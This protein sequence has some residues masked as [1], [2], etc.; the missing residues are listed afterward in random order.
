MSGPPRARLAYALLAPLC[1]LGLWYHVVFVVGGAYLLL[2]AAASARHAALAHTAGLT[3]GVWAS[4]RL[5]PV[6]ASEGPAAGGLVAGGPFEHLTPA[7]A[8]AALGVA[9]A[10]AG[11]AACVAAPAL[12]TSGATSVSGALGLS[13]AFGAASG[14]FAGALARAL[15]AILPSPAA[16]LVALRVEVLAP[17]LAAAAFGPA[18]AHRGGLVRTGIGAALCACVVAHLGASSVFGPASARWAARFAALSSYALCFSL[19]LVEPLAP[20]AD[21]ART[22]D[23]LVLAQ[24]GPFGRLLLTSGRGAFQLYVDASLRLSTID[25]ARAR[26]ALAHPALA[27]ASR[28][29]RVL[30]VGGG[31]GAVAAEALRYGDVAEVTIVEPDAELVELGR[32][33]PVLVR[34]NGGALGSPKVRVVYEDPLPFL[35]R[36]GEPFD[37]AL[38]DMGEP[39]APVRSKLYTTYFFNLVRERLTEGGT[40]AVRTA[41]P[42][43]ARRAHWCVVRTLEAAGLEVLAYR[44]GL[45][46]SGEQGYALFGRGRLVRPDPSRLPPGLAFLDA[47]ELDALFDWPPDVGPLPVEVNRLY[48]QVLH[49]YRDEAAL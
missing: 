32:S 45:P 29:A 44:A 24:R 30:V 3:A 20:W 46:A 10:L 8:L 40:G 4:R 19:A 33:Q 42:L 9:Q 23:P 21:L 1:G 7:A 11:A 49:A 43:A 34:E 18:L 25:A 35:A 39:D 16:L 31:D 41:P 6:I 37:V 26:E 14:A 12:F 13:L 47:G 28:R 15:P 27:A 22:P 5:V 2:D 38:L 36:G 48:H 17:V